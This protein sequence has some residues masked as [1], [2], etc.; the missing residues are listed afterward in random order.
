[1]TE[2][3]IVVNVTGGLQDQCGFVDEAG[4]YLDPETHF[5]KEWGTNADGR[6]RQ[7]G[8]WVFP[9][10]PNARSLIGSPPTPY[11]FDSRCSWEEAGQRLREVYDL[12][13][14]ERIR[15]GALGRQYAIFMG[16]TAEK[17]A[18]NIMDGIDATLA[19]WQPRKRFE[20]IKV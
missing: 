17:M 13:I 16:M 20:L 19:N 12:P 5:T 3:L 15:R 7:H 11:I 14:E 9:V 1:M 8:E 6:Y 18:T 10:Y 2:R 4:E